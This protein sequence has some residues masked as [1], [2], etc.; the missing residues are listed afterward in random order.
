MGA[1]SRADPD[2]RGRTGGK[3]FLRT[4][5]FNGGFLGIGPGA[6]PFL[7]WWTTHCVRNCVLDLGRGLHLLQSW[8]ALVPAL[9]P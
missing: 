9:F 5:V 7:A 6:E 2:K 3:A 8:L 1:Q 4:G